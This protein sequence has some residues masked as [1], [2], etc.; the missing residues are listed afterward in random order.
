LACLVILLSCSAC[1][2]SKRLAQEAGAVAEAINAL[3]AST[4]SL[5]KEFDAAS[6]TRDA[7]RNQA[8]GSNPGAGDIAGEIKSLEE[9]KQ[10]LEGEIAAMTSDFDRYR[11]NPGQ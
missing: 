4:E 9:S 3:D 7:L 10:V 5:Q 6:S 8:A 1:S 2:E 11:K